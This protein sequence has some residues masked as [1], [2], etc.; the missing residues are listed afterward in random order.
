M[1]L[2]SLSRFSFCLDVNLKFVNLKTISRIGFPCTCVGVRGEYDRE[3]DSISMHT[4]NCHG[5]KHPLCCGQ[6][7][8]ERDLQ[9][10]ILY[11]KHR[12]RFL[13]SDDAHH[14]YNTSDVE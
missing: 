9:E 8:L 5:P 11:V 10:N 7:M 3:K 14:K 4:Q 13:L 2:L 6:P 1:T 12:Y